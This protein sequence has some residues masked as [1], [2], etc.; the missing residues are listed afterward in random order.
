[1]QGHSIDWITDQDLW[2]LPNNLLGMAILYTRALQAHMGVQKTATIVPC[3]VTMLSVPP[4]NNV[5][6]L[7]IQLTI[8]RETIVPLINISSLISVDQYPL[9]LKTLAVVSLEL[10]TKWTSYSKCSPASETGCT[11]KLTVEEIKIYSHKT[12][13]SKKQSYYQQHRR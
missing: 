11:T 10:L 4:S 1:M 7:S 13:S 12:D 5:R 6:W 2:A 9:L 8:A 3:F